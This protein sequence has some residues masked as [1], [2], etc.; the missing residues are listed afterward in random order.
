MSMMNGAYLNNVLDT[1][2]GRMSRMLREQHNSVP[3]SV[4]AVDCA[5]S[6]LINIASVVF[7][8][9]R[10]SSVTFQGNNETAMIESD[11]HSIVISITGCCGGGKPKFPLITIRRLK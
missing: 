5:L 1:L 4:N 11:K 6:G 2:S 10:I 9:E 7:H 8:G 3:E